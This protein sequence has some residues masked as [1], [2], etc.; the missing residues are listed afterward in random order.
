MK[1][2]IFLRIEYVLQT[3]PWVETCRASFRIGKKKGKRERCSSG[4]Y[5]DLHPGFRPEHGLNL[6]RSIL[7]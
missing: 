4:C 6:L 2:S 1:I 7:T 5:E 3:D